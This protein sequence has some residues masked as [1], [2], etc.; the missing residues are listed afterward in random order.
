MNT[1]WMLMG[2]YNGM[3]IVPVDTVIRDFFPS[4]NRETFL[5]KVADGVIALPLVRMEASQKSAKGVYLTDLA[6]YID[7]RRDEALADFHRF[8]G[9]A[10]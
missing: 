1:Q 7:R 2:R 3:P 8:H 5:R 4:M 6:A 9:L 10:A